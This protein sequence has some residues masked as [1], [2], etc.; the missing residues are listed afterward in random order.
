MKR[1]IKFRAKA[2]N[3][4]FFKGVWIDGCYK[5]RLWGEKLVDMITDGAHEIPIQIE[6]LG[7]LT[8]YATRMERKSTKE[9]YLYVDNE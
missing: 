2:I 5:N 8:G 7:Q 6:T 3:D 1:E 9:T 4:N